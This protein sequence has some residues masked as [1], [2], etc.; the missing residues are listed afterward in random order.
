L[1]SSVSSWSFSS[2]PVNEDGRSGCAAVSHG[3]PDLGEQLEAGHVGRRQIENPTPVGS[4]GDAAAASAAAPGWRDMVIYVAVGKE[5]G[6][7]N[8]LGGSSSDHQQPRTREAV[9]KL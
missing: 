1:S 3:S 2:R 9:M 6:T 7:L 5:L 8:L 4:A